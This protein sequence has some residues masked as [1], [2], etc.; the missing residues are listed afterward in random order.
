MLGCRTLSVMTLM[1][2]HE[3]ETIGVGEAFIGSVGSVDDHELAGLPPRAASGSWYAHC[4]EQGFVILSK[5]L[6]S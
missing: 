5:A 4:A 3:H 1:C 6:S 2:H